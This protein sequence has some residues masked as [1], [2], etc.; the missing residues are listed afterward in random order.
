M[1][2]TLKIKSCFYSD[3]DN[4]LGIKRTIKQQKKLEN[5]FQWRLGTNYN[6]EITK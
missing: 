5:H 4:G 6:S 2:A 3:H 1:L